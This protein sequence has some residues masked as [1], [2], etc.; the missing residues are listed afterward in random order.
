[1]NNYNELKNVCQ[2]FGALHK[3]QRDSIQKFDPD[4]NSRICLKN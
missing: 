1:M 4:I 2:R 3:K